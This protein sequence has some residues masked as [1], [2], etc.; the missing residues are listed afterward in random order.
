MLL[1]RVVE[2]VKDQNWTAVVLDFAIVV[3][4]V[5]VGLQAAN[6]NE[7]RGDRAEAR[8]YYEQLLLDL[9][10]D[11]VTGEKA[12]RDAERHDAAGDL[13]FEALTDDAFVIGNPG[14]FVRAFVIAGFGYFPGA[15]TKT[16]DEMTSTG[17]L[18][19]LRNVELKRRILQYYEITRTGRQWDG[20]M[21]DQQA[22]YDATIAGLV[23]REHMR[24]IRSNDLSATREEAERLLER[25]RDRKERILEMLIPLAEV[26]TR[27]RS[28]GERL[29]HRASELSALIGAE[30]GTV[31]Q[32]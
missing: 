14:E 15:T 20:L 13:I 5:F 4:G 17:N 19:L 7:A 29:A 32:P 26:Q 16:I 1:R 8:R 12:V 25:A 23:S 30:L 18:R 3:V 21:R 22:S 6:W 2:H 11:I 27:L 31:T 28:D 10:F 9:E 24:M